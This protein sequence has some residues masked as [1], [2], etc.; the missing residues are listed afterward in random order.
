MQV[1][2]DSLLRYLALW[3]AVPKLLVIPSSG[4]HLLQEFVFTV[5]LW[6]SPSFPGPF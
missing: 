3:N 5:S 4:L 2:N 1:N 6:P